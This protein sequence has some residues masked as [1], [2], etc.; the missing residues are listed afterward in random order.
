MNKTEEELIWESYYKIYLEQFANITLTPFKKGKSLYPNMFDD[1]VEIEN[2]NFDHMGQDK[3]DIKDDFIQRGFYGIGMLQNEKLI[4]YIYGFAMIFDDNM[5]D[6]DFN[7]LEFY[8]SDFQKS[9]LNGGI[10]MA[11]KLFTPKNTI[12]V[13][14]FVV[15]AEFRNSIYSGKMIMEFIKNLKINTHYKYILMEA[16]PNTM[17]LIKKRMDR[18]SST[19]VIAIQKNDNGVL[20][21]L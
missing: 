1:M 9:I 3:E 8:D 7:D 12:Y 11:R 13:S 5:V 21:K 20:L 14:N 2:N 4:G 6:I 19:K 16:M 15:N 17:D 18:I 10:K